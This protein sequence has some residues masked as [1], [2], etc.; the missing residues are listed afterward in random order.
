MDILLDLL[1]I[2]CGAKYIYLFH[3]LIKFK[4]FPK[5]LGRFEVINKL[6]TIGIIKANLQKRLFLEI[7]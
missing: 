3:G 6:S 1:K 7:F 4:I 2:N 5:I